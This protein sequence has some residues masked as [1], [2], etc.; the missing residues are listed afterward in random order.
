MKVNGYEIKADA[1][2][3]GADL[4][5]ADL[6]GANLYGADL[7]G[8]NLYGADLR[9][10][11]LRHANLIG[12]NLSG[13][14]LEGADLSAADLRG[15]DLRRADLR[16]TDLRRAKGILSFTGAQ[17]LAI[18]YKDRIQI[19]CQDHSIKLWVTLYQTI[20]HKNNY[21]ESQVQSY[22]LFIKMCALKQGI[23]TSITE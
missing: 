13:A 4:Y 10:A 5:G 22:G 14:D 9:G 11:D 3:I 7:E 1:D 16:R 6:E 21:T 15:A 12:A 23:I 20:G 17:H 18:C 8:A 2:L 19:G